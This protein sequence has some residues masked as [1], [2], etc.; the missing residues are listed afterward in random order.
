MAKILD[1]LIN[2]NPVLRQ[3]SAPIDKEKAGSEKITGFC[4]D[5]ALTMKEKDGVGLA[6]PQV[7]R[8]IRAIAVATK[9]GTVCLVNPVITKKSWAKEWGPEG[10]LSVPD[11][12]GEVRRHK[13]TTCVY[14]D[15]EGNSQ[16]I[17][18]EGLLARIL[19][20]EIDHLDGVL[21]IDKARR[22][23]KLEPG[24][25]ESSE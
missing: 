4:A 21:F 3:K 13:K 24:E 7:G 9:N 16:T 14:V 25:K 2:P 5:L 6:A 12:F 23:K 20:H 8:N 22:V 18:A 11:V 17:Q 10:C 19:Q 1:I 15:V